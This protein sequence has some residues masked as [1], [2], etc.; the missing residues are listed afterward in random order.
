MKQT[1]IVNL[2][3]TVNDSTNNQQ[4]HSVLTHRHKAANQLLQSSNALCT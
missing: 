1:K 2:L 4:H 3:C